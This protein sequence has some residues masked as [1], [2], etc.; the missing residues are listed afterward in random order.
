M[1]FSIMAAA[2]LTHCRDRRFEPRLGIDEEVRVD[3]DRLAGLDSRSDLEQAVAFQ[4]GLHLAWL[5]L[6]RRALDENNRARPGLQDRAVGN[7]DAV[8]SRLLEENIGITVRL[9]QTSGVVELETNLRRSRF[10]IER[11]RDERDTAGPGPARHR[12]RCDL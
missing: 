11:R 8:P 1:S 6:P 5:E 7:R 9:Q 10:L 12:P 3:D 4:S 2:S